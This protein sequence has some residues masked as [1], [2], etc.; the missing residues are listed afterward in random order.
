MLYEVIT[1]DSLGHLAGDELLQRLA[2]N[3]LKC[4]RTSD[5][6]ARLGGDEFAILIEEFDSPR[7]VTEIAERIQLESQRPYLIGNN[8]VQVSA[9][10][11]IVLNTDAYSST[12][13]IVRDA[14]IAMYRAKEL[15]KARFQ[16]FN[17]KLHKIAFETLQMESELP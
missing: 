2:R 15:G 9:S 6:V 10:I 12:E 3:F 8:D 13:A 5:T 14:D 7:T 11:G 16:I 17:K 1:N 4:V